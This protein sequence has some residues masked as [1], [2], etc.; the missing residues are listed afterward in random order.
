MSRIQPVDVATATGK[1]AELLATTRQR[2][3]GTPNLFTTA[4]HSPAALDAML[5]LFASLGK[6][7]VGPKVGEQ[8]ALAVAQQNACGYCLAAHTTIGAMHGL[9]TT[10]MQAARRAES[11]DIKTAAL[12]QFAVQVL[13]AR[14]HVD[15]AA[16]EA[17]R[18]AD[19]TD[20][21]IV[22]VVAHIALN[23]FTNFLNSV[24]ETDVDFPVVALE[25]QPIAA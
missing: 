12:L 1:T 7:S 21:E 25:L 13:E 8:I 14:G 24:S 6:S 17:V 3:G 19:A 4:A 15:D 9:T 10:T 22:E 20:G 23:V 5:G 18:K 2:F 11:T 16:L